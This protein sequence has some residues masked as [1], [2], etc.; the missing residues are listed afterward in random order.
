MSVADAPA[1]M[2]AGEEFDGTA[3]R[4]ILQEIAEGVRAQPPSPH[5]V[6]DVVLPLAVVITLLANALMIGIAWGR[7]S[8]RMEN[9]EGAAQKLE[10]RVT[11]GESAIRSIQDR[12][13]DAERDIKEDERRF[14]LLDDYTRG[15]IDRLPYKSPPPARW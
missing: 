11:G 15:R 12:M 14:G 7:F 5:P 8:Q 1:T 9:Y 3:I 10:S 6:K 4:R 2:M 13:H